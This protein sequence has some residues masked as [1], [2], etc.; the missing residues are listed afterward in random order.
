M[1]SHHL[2]GN[3]YGAPLE[4]SPMSSTSSLP[5]N[6]RLPASL[7]PLG[8]LSS[9][10]GGNSGVPVCV[11]ML[12]Q[13]SYGLST[14]SVS[15]PAHYHRSSST[16]TRDSS[17]RRSEVHTGRRTEAEDPLELSFSQH[18]E[19]TLLRVR[20]EFEEAARRLSVE[21]LYT[22]NVEL[23]SET[24]L[25]QQE[26]MRE[27][28]LV[29]ELHAGVSLSLSTTDNRQEQTS[30]RLI[31]CLQ[32]LHRKKGKLLQRLNETQKNRL[33]QEKNLNE[34][35][36]NIRT[37]KSH[38]KKEESVIA[39]R[40]QRRIEAMQCKR[41]SLETAIQRES[42]SV[43]QLEGL[44]NEF[45]RSECADMTVVLPDGSLAG[46]PPPPPSSPA[47]CAANSSGAGSTAAPVVASRS[48]SQLSS[49]S[50]GLGGKTSDLAALVT[51]TTTTTASASSTAVHTP[52]TAS[53]SSPRADDSTAASI[54]FMRKAIAVLEHL[55]YDATRQEAAYRR[56][57]EELI[58]SVDSEMRRKRDELVALQSIQQELKEGVGA[59]PTAMP[60]TAPPA[61][62][63]YLIGEDLVLTDALSGRGGSRGGRVG[64]LGP[65]CPS[66][67]QHASTP[68]APQ[69]QQTPVV[70]VVGSSSVSTTGGATK[71]GGVSSA[72]SLLDNY[73]E[74]SV[75]G[76]LHAAV[77]QDPHV[78][79]K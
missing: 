1:R 25:L 28:Q 41:A 39:D 56:K 42:Y 11:G 2:P 73:S 33:Q 16:A 34:V 61:G 46:H 38:L 59:A 14:A 64:S 54:R 4:D 70:T 29:H 67:H 66:R 44:V 22:Q 52:T 17:T 18:S 75:G 65:R 62:L 49:A 30:N 26:V 37:L 9:S 20:E 23:A 21:D 8:P 40:I 79:T 32:V 35:R 45:Q 10:T 36:D 72:S 69:L 15:W 55:R 12:P 27:R 43:H 6:L 53:S 51:T 63:T 47:P 24:R 77:L 58:G 19:E 71:G 13:P 60:V 48:H 78:L 74:E 7:R 3:K 57:T 50:S 68:L 76:S 31:R 5:N